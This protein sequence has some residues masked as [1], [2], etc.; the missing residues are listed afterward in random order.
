MKIQQTQKI[1][2]QFAGDKYKVTV[3]H[4]SWVM[5]VQ[6]L[7]KIHWFKRIFSTQDYEWKRIYFG[8]VTPLEEFT[9]FF[10]DTNKS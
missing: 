9:K 4:G 10:N 7:V 3:Y 1:F 5:E 8:H 2:E 6:E